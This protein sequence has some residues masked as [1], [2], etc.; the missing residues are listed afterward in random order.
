MPV[1]AFR[2]DAVEPNPF[3]NAVVPL[4]MKWFVLDTWVQNV[5]INGSSAVRLKLSSTGFAGDG[6]HSSLLNA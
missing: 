5:A 3:A 6:I 4:V 1:A 2:R